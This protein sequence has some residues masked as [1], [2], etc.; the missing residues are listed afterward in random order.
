MSQSKNVVR[1]NTWTANVFNSVEDDLK[2]VLKEVIMENPSWGWE[3]LSIQDV[4]ACA[5][6]LLPPIYA[7]KGKQPH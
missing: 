3:Q 6:N 2:Q 7:K 5:I 1:V 4:Y